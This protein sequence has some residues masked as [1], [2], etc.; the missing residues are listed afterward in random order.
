MKSEA[1]GVFCTKTPIDY[2]MGEKRGNADSYTAE[3]CFGPVWLVLP[4]NS[5]HMWEVG[6]SGEIMGCL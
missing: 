4:A 5:V 1:R 3:R 2:L 6:G